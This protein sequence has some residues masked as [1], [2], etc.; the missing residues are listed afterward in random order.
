MLRSDSANV[1]LQR[2]VKGA[3]QVTAAGSAKNHKEGIVFLA[4]LGTGR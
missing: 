2:P 3:L 4:I 1:S